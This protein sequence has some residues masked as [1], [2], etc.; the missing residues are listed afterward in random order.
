MIRT[1][2]KKLR[3]LL[4]FGGASNEH[5]ISLMSAQNIAAA[6][7]KDKYEVDYCYIDKIGRWWLVDDVMMSIEPEI[8]LIPVFGRRHFLALPENETIKPDVILPVVHG[9]NGEDGGV[10]AVAEL[11]CISYAGPSMIGAAVTLDKDLTKRLLRDAGIPV[12]KW[13]T[14]RV[15]AK[16]PTYAEAVDVLGEPLFVKPNASGSSVGVVKVHNGSEYQQALD[17]AAKHDQMV[18]IEEFTPGQEIEAAVLGNETVYVSDP[19]E[20]QPG[21]E[22][23]SY[24]DKYN[25]SSRAKVKIP[26]RL[27]EDMRRQAREIAESSYVATRGH[28]MAR[29]DM[30]VVEDDQIYVGEI[31]SIPGFTDISMYPKLWQHEG[32]SYPELLDRLISLAL[33]K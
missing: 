2:M 17:E 19:G 12:A 30:F 3:V 22:F 9:K 21:E 32:L 10:Q 4:I 29:V 25:P 31:N 14:W 26:A 8:Q 18:I 6:L 16:R 33:E 24:S 7:D 27:S 1:V 13:M 28:G 11:L 5:E 20:I 23:Y 15:N